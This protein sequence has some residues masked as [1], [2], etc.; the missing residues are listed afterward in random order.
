MIVSVTGSPARSTSQLSR[1]R[2]SSSQNSRCAPQAHSQ[3]TGGEDG[4]LVGANESSASPRPMPRDPATPT[5]YGPACVT[6]RCFALLGAFPARRDEALRGALGVGGNGGGRV[7]VGRS[8]GMGRAPALCVG[9]VLRPYA[10]VWCAVRRGA[11][12][13][14]LWVWPSGGRSLSACITVLLHTQAT[15]GMAHFGF[16]VSLL[17]RR[18]RRE[19][20][21]DD[22]IWSVTFSKDTTFTNGKCVE[23]I[24]DHFSPCVCK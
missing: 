15:S 10:C 16:D 6:R 2:H 22:G 23:G 14:L 4:G 21:Y 12:F 9:P 3:R 19:P 8:G 5:S 24:Y 11:C 17:G 18:A 1:S 7:G 13:D 20:P